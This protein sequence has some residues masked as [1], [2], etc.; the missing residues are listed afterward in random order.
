MGILQQDGSRL[1]GQ[2][3]ISHPIRRQAGVSITFDDDYNGD[4]SIDDLDGTINKPQ[5][6]L[7]EAAEKEEYEPLEAGIA[8]TLERDSDTFFCEDD[9]TY[10]VNRFVLH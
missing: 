9:I 10:R 5:N 1:V 3:E 4:D 2:C 7:F 6:V 8:R